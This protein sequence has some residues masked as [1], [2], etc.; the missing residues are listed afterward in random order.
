[1]AKAGGLLP[2]R[3]QVQATSAPP[4]LHLVTR[5]G[6]HARHRAE[7]TTDIGRGRKQS[8]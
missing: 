1:M 7:A 2:A 8:G 6:A 4:A 5:S 3:S